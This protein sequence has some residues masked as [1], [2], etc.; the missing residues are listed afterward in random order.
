LNTK[1]LVKKANNKSSLSRD[2]GALI[3]DRVFGIIKE[4]VIK[5]KVFIV[6]N[7]GK[8]VVEHREMQKEIDYKTKSEILVPPKDKIKFVPLFLLRK[9]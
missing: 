9:R 2:K 4:T 1:S 8:F 5:D 6:E 7:F 3:F